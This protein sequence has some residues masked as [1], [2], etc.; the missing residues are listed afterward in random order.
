MAN[1]LLEVPLRNQELDL[2]CWAAVASAV[3]GYFQAHMPFL[4][5]CQVA[6]RLAGGANCCANPLP[7]NF[8]APL[9]EAL[10]AIGLSGAQA[11]APLPFPEVAHQIIDLRFPLGV[12]LVGNGVG[13]HFVLIVGCD[14]VTKEVTVADPSGA[15]GLPSWRGAMPYSKLLNDYGS[16]QGTCTHSILIG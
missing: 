13:G 16:W 9:D 3:S 8:R 2:W 12:R 4:V 1:R 14:D 11:V 5:P 6:A 15:P 10:R 7:C